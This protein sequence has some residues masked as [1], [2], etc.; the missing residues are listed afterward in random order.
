MASAQVLPTKKQEHLEAGKRRLEEFRKKKAAEKAKKASSSSLVNG[1]EVGSNEKQPAETVRVTVSD[2]AGTS[3]GPAGGLTE[4]SSVISSNGDNAIDFSKKKEHASSNNAY[5]SPSTDDYNGFSADQGYKR[6]GVSG[7]PRPSDVGDRYDIKGMNNDVEKDTG[8]I[9]SLPFA[10]TSDHPITLR[11]QAS[12]ESESNTRQFSFYGDQSSEHELSSRGSLG[13]GLGY[14]QQS[15]AK[16]SPQNSVSTF[17]QSETSNF[18]TMAGGPPSS[19]SLYEDLIEPSTSARGFSQEVGK[20]IRNGSADFSDPLSFRFGEGKLSSSAN[21][22]TQL[23]TSESTDYGYDAR[24]LSNHVEPVS[25]TPDNSSRR[26]RPSFLDS[27]NVSGASS[28]SPFQQ[29]QPEESYFSSSSKSNG[30]SFLGSLPFHKPSMGD[31][32]ATPYLFEHSNKSS[33][34]PSA[35]VDQQRPIVESSL[36]RKHEFYSSKQ[37]EDFA[38]LEQHIEDLTQEKFSLQ[39]ALEASRSLAESLA[40]ENSSLTETY[41]QQ[42]SVVDQLKSD[43]ETLQEEIKAHMVE[44]EAVRNEYANAQLECNAADE[45]SKLLA[46]EVIGLEEKALRLRST[47][48]KLERQLENSQAEISSY[49]KRLSSLEKDRADLHSTINALQEEKKLLQSMLRKASANEKKADVSKSTTGKKD[50]FTSTEDLEA[51]EEVSPDTVDQEMRDASSF[52][53]LPENGQSSFD[54]SSVNIPP[55]QMRTID[56][57][58]TLVSEL[59]LEKEELL[60]S[61]ASETSQCSKLKEL[62]YE[63]SRKLEAQTQRLELLTA[64]SMA[65]ENT[66]VRQPISHDLPDSTPYADEGDEVVERVLGWIMTLFPGG[67][68]R[69]RTSKL[70]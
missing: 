23:Q 46:S 43:L 5:S 37:N 3:D 24:S 65:N 19:S 62:N 35:G 9:G 28:G 29:A 48:L 21:G 55:D 14:S 38:A 42:R 63:L 40:S 59:T 53:M 66:P 52:S 70:L 61:L 41:N 16:I 17:L 33:L 11:P 45:R 69:R 22:S 68:S 44:L 57:I 15:V 4:A 25:V 6:Y 67:P 8:T 1:S 2:G 13:A 34:S 58:N 54:V 30:T 47:E 36:D 12:Q 64:Q 60:Q 50:V 18:S 56:N 51:N 7:F 27:L 26:S 39:R 32:P 49:K 31:G 10:Q 20:R